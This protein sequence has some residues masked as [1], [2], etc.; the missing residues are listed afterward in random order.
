MCVGLVV[1]ELVEPS[2]HWQAE[3]LYI[4]CCGQLR[5]GDQVECND[6]GARRGQLRWGRITAGG[7]RAAVL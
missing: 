6:G 2:V 3:V 7:R 1:S 4:W 5:N